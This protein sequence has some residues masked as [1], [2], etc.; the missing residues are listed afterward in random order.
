MAAE[1]PRCADAT[2]FASDPRMLRA[3]RDHFP[4][5]R[6]LWASRHPPLPAQLRALG[7]RGV[8]SV[9]QASLRYRGAEH[10]LQ[11]AEELGAEY[12]VAV[13][14]LSM[15]ARLAELAPAR[16]VTVLWAEMELLHSGCPGASL[17]PEYDPDRD[18]IASGRHYRFRGFKRV[19]RVELVLEDW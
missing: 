8:A 7:E 1:L 14:P 4:A 18:A 10:A 6:L 13:L 19:V 15:V 16:G 3:L 9:L 5:P 2:L 12:I 17:C 11:V